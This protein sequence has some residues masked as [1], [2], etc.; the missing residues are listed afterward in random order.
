M[1]AKI[2]FRNTDYCVPLGT[3][4][5]AQQGEGGAL[6]KPNN[7]KREKRKKGKN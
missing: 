6:K 4:A 1:K 3:K 2:N 7:C 5:Y